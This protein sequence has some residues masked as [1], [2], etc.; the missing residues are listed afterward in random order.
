MT[1][2]A[3][4]SIDAQCNSKDKWQNPIMTPDHFMFV[5]LW[6]AAKA[7]KLYFYNNYET[8]KNYFYNYAK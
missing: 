1:S 8:I 7:I 3:D 2:P 6:V 5:S 4:G